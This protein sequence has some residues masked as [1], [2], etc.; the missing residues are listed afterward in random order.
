MDKK[1]SIIV[2]LYNS[3]KHL[4]ECLNSAINQSYQNLEVLAVVNGNCSD[5]T[6]F[7]ASEYAQSD[8]RIRVLKNTQNSVITE[9]LK[10][11]FDN[12][13]G[14]YFMIL[15]GDDELSLTAVKDLM[16]VAGDTDADM[17]TGEINTISEAGDCIA[18][19]G[20]PEFDILSP[21][22]YLK[23]AIPY[24]DFLYH[25]KLFRRKLYKDIMLPPAFLGHDVLI[26]YQLAVNANKIVSCKKVVHYF[27]QHL[28]SVSMST[29]LSRLND[30][31]T[32]HVLLDHLF[33]EKNIYDDEEIRILFETQILRILTSCLI[34]GKSVFYKNN[35]QAI[36]RQL[37]NGT[38]DDKRCRAYL[39]A[40]KGVLFVLDIY[41][42]M[43]TLAN[44]IVYGVDFFRKILLR[45]KR[46]H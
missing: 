44:V 46:Y 29:T 12:M 22:Q 2:L 13:Q 33:R 38:L 39:K 9:G 17:I 16:D 30:S 42:K 27:R 11:G 45:I 41:R 18:I 3:E 36:T 24:M 40:W 20:R 34:F 15:E 7:I 19:W 21:V 35:K 26:T 28:S 10:L 23:L 1:V 31:Y 8:S 4:K 5:N 32:C 37:N 43:P 6:E 25:G 14:E